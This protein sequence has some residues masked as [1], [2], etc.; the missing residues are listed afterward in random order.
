[1]FTCCHVGGDLGLNITRRHLNPSR[2][3]LLAESKTRYQSDKKAHNRLRTYEGQRSLRDRK[4][5]Y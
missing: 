1:M 3:K 2:P 5:S 4:G